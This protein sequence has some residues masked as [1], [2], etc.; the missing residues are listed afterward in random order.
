M[1][2]GRG[3]A[4]HWF[5]GH[6]SHANVFCCRSV[7]RMCIWG[8]SAGTLGVNI[9]KKRGLVVG[10]FSGPES[11]CVKVESIVLRGKT[12]KLW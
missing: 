5:Q 9:V 3:F 2:M 11:R 1:P 4:K 10:T 7:A 8:W 12:R 6:A